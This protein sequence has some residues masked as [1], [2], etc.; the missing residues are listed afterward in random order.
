MFFNRRQENGRRLRNQQGEG[1]TGDIGFM[2]LPLCQESPLEL[3]VDRTQLC[4]SEKTIAIRGH[5]R[6]QTASEEFFSKR[7][8]AAFKSLVGLPDRIWPEFRHCVSADSILQMY[9]KRDPLISSSWTQ[10]PPPHF[11][12]L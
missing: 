9:P 2:V 5:P 4:S 10:I 6:A 1:L 8:L 3:L 11:A 12:A 7:I